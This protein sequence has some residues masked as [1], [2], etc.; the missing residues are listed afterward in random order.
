MLLPLEITVISSQIYKRIYRPEDENNIEEQ[1][2]RH[3][4]AIEMMDRDI[5]RIIAIPVL[6]KISPTFEKNQIG[7]II[8]E[9]I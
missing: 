5:E 7:G 8:N 6:E 4:A 1:I 2:A 9:Y 3:K